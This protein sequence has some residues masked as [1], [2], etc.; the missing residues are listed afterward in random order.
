MFKIFTA[1]F[2]GITSLFFNVTH[3]TQHEPTN[4]SPTVSQQGGQTGVQNG[5]RPV[6]PQE[7]YTVCL[8]KTEGASCSFTAPRGAV[9]GTCQNPSGEQMVCVPTMP[10]QNSGRPI[11]Y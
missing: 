9:T 5:K 10:E 1:I 8:G 7:A 2:L 11:N 4:P 3:S 6:P